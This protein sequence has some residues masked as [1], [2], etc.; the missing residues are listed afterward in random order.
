[1]TT[2]AGSNP[3]AT[4][5][6]GSHSP[7]GYSL[8]AGLIAKIVMTFTFLLVILGDGDRRAPQC[9]APT[10][11]G[12]MLALI[13]LITIPLTNTSVNAARSTGPTLI[14]GLFGHTELFSQIWLFWIA[15]ILGAIA[16]GF[17]Y[18]AIFESSDSNITNPD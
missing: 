4:N 12:L 7:Q 10:A 14:V 13:H 2:F 11:I 5:R 16:A 15:P 6:F 3:P 18:R 17:F 8:L 1:M 9:F